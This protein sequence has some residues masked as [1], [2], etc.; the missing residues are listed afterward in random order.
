MIDSSHSA[1]ERRPDQ[2][3]PALAVI[4]KDEQRSSRDS[5]GA[6]LRRSVSLSAGLCSMIPGWQVMASAVRKYP[7]LNSKPGRAA[8]A[9]D[10]HIV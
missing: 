8:R 7:E 2:V 3:R 10:L 6:Y 1:V 4:P 9:C 5:L